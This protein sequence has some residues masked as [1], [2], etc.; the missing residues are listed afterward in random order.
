M[1]LISEQ[2]SALHETPPV[3][4]IQTTKL[5]AIPSPPVPLFVNSMKLYIVLEENESPDVEDDF[6]CDVRGAGVSSMSH[7]KPD[8]LPNGW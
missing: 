6:S 4:E 5:P 8:L 2:W 3:S 7:G 1:I